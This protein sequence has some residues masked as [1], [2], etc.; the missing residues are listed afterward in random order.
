MGQA[1]P[2]QYEDLERPVAR[3][4]SWESANVRWAV[5]GPPQEPDRGPVGYLRCNAALNATGVQALQV[6]GLDVREDQAVRAVVWG[7]PYDRTSVACIR[8]PGQHG[9]HWVPQKWLK[10]LPEE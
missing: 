4:P 8:F 7:N 1:L 10:R 3:D 9:D 5:N 6:R 2:F